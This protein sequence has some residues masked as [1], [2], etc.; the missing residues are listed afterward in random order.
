MS[1]RIHAIAKEVDKASKEILEILQ[2]RGYDVK[3]ASS[4]LDNITAQSLI[5]EF[6]VTEQEDAVSEPPP[7]E[8]DDSASDEEESSD[9]DSAPADSGSVPIVKSK[10][11]LEK[12]RLEKEALENPPDESGDDEETK[13]SQDAGSD[14]PQGKAPS[15]PPPPTKRASAPPPPTSAGK[16]PVPPSVPSPG[17]GESDGGVVEGNKI[18]LKPPIVVRDFAGLIGLKPFQLISE[19]MEMGIFASMNQTVEE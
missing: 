5:D 18:I 6:K 13:P 7:A 19:L 2:E 9:E 10:A 12:E 4:T 11:D 1:V 16:A 15:V 17:S 3:S 8:P 14:S